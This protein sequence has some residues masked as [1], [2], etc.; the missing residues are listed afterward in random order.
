MAKSNFDSRK[1]KNRED[2]IEFVKGI[3]TKDN[4]FKVDLDWLNRQEVHGVYIDNK[5]RAGFVYESLPL[6]NTL[7]DMDEEGRSLFL[8]KHSAKPNKILGVTCFWISNSGRTRFLINYTWAIF[9]ASLILK[10]ARLRYIVFTS[11]NDRMTAIF[12]NQSANKIFQKKM[13]KSV[14]S[15]FLI[16]MS[17]LNLFKFVRLIFTR[18]KKI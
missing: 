6:S 17:W 2:H 10:I 13:K 11:K 3:S 12:E 1:L 5:L 16:E 18:P 4:Q 15:T 8:A 14:S 9:L 7:Q